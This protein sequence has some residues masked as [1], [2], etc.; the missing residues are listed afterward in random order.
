VKYEVHSLSPIAKA[1]WK[2]IGEFHL[3]FGETLSMARERIASWRALGHRNIRLYR[4]TN[5]GKKTRLTA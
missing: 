2:H 5:A 4:V 1:W 3:A